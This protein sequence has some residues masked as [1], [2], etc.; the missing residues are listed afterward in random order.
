[1]YGVIIYRFCC[2]KKSICSF[3]S[4]TKIQWERSLLCSFW[5]LTLEIQPLEPNFVWAADVLL[6]SGLQCISF[7][8]VTHNSN[9]KEGPVSIGP[10]NF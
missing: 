7:L 3:F 5:E 9:K 2:S 8:Q 1:M 4:I 10:L 6:R